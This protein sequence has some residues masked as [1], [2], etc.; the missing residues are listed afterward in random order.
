MTPGPDNDQ[1]SLIIKAAAAAPDHGR[2]R[3]W[4]FVAI[5]NRDALAAI[6]LDAAREL[7]PDISE[8]LLQREAERAHNAPCLLAVIARIERDHAIA[9][10]NEQWVSVGAALQNILLAAEDLGFHAMIVSG[11]KVGTDVVR[12]GFALSEGE[13]LVG[14]V[15]IGSAT[16]P[17]KDRQ[18]S[19]DAGVL[20]V[21]NGGL[22]EV[23]TSK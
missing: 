17:A 2:I 20:T 15:A 8:D 6:F 19:P 7:D 4:R 3:P 11:Q 23:R 16:V 9:P 22:R 1:F 14:F 21:W 13:E 10:P 12:R 5:G 18:D